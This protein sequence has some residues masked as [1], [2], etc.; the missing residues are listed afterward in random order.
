MER[1]LSICIPT[2]NRLDKLKIQVENL[3]SVNDNRFNIVVSDNSSTDGTNEF[4]HSIKDERLVIVKQSHVSGIENIMKSLYSA[5]A[6]F[7]LLLL[8]KD[9]INITYLPKLL[10]D[11][12][13]TKASYGYCSLQVQN[14]IDKS[15]NYLMCSY[16]NFL[17]MAYPCNHPSG[18]FYKTERLKSEI[19]SVQKLIKKN[20]PFIPD[21][22]FAHF[23]SNNDALII[24]YPV[25]YTETQADAAA[26]KSFTY[27]GKN[28]W[29]APDKVVERYQIFLNDLESIKVEVGWKI[30]LRNLLIRRCF[31]S[32]TISYAQIMSNIDICTHYGVEPQSFSYKEVVRFNNQILD[33]LRKGYNNICTFSLYASY[34]ES[35]IRIIFWAL[36]KV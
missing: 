12:K 11:L 29:F 9:K 13:N 35:N 25:V 31:S 4:L 10:D 2:F 20:F 15:T 28:V 23:A 22:L 21:V 6:I 26:K 17:K 32:G 5:T 14:K 34:L 36:K 24:N 7:A 18:Y 16:R 1:I 30:K 3:L 27:I 19:F 8:D 33:S